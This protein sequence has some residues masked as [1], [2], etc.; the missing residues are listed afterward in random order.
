CPSVVTRSGVAPVAALAERKKACGP[1][2]RTP[3]R[4]RRPAPSPP[5]P[6]APWPG[7]NARRTWN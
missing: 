7:R 1:R 5:T 3:P 2:G 4:R 6:R